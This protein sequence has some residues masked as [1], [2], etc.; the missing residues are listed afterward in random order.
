MPE[1]KPFEL[2]PD[3]KAMVKAEG[4]VLVVAG[5]GA[6][7][8]RVLIARA[9]HLVDK[10]IPPD[11]VLLLTFTVR[12][13]RELKERLAKAGLE[14]IRVETFHAL[15]YD[16]L[17]ETTGKPPRLAEE[18]EL[19]GITKEVL[20]RTGLK[21]SPRKGL[22]KLY[23]GGEAFETARSEYLR[24]LAARGLYD[25]HRL[26]TEAERL[27]RRDFSGYH[28]LIDEF[29]DLSPEIF[30][31]LRI[32]RGAEF[33]LVGDPAQAIYGFRGA[34]PE[35]LGAF[36][37]EFLP[38]LKV[39]ALRKSYRVPE[40]LLRIAEGL[41]FD[42]FQ[43][44]ISL[45]ATR[46]GGEILGWR[47]PSVRAE[48]IG[49]AKMITDLLGGTRMETADYS[50][51]SPGDLLVLARLRKVL[52]PL[53]EALL[54][55]RL[56]VAEPEEEAQRRARFVRELARG[57]EDPKLFREKVSGLPA[58]LKED[59]GDILSEGLEKERLVARLRLIS[60]ADF[61][62][63]LA[64]GINLLTIHGAKGLEA[65]VV[66]LV[67]AEKGLLPLE[68]LQ[69]SDPAEERR[70]LYVAFT[71]AREKFIFT[72]APGRVLFGKKLS[73]KVS[74]W[75]KGIPQQEPR[76]SP[77]RPKQGALFGG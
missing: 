6:G 30:A 65:R 69:D 7:K 50:D 9:A 8:T 62:R 1:S 34:R 40:G 26:L 51:L 68:L 37:K 2:D 31:F 23:Y 53:R 58:D 45:T 54:K 12:T 63:P 18:E 20:R 60:K 3:Q 14:G 47:Y 17:Y 74:P 43:L 15:A 77:R 46:P 57:A 35:K 19:E 11:R 28:L 39:M 72:T 42:P 21:L 71:R 73:G 4:S 55:E 24:Y 29:Q 48:A 67:G 32:F 59:L 52:G 41:R 25:Y 70:L 61:L 22:E 64:T 56:P 16:L 49:V 5:P 13:R 33:F 75:L 27:V 44:G 38:E 10:G 76:V 36:L 66:I